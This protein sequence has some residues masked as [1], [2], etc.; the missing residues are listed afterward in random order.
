MQ[1][2]FVL[3]YVVIERTALVCGQC[4]SFSGYTAQL[5]RDLIVVMPLQVLSVDL[6]YPMKECS[7][8]SML[9]TFISHIKVVTT[10]MRLL[11]HDSLFPAQEHREARRQATARVLTRGIYQARGPLSAHG[12]RSRCPAVAP[13]AL[14]DHSA[15]RRALPPELHARVWQSLHG[16]QES[17]K[18]RGARQRDHL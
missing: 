18:P 2:W 4:V 10:H 11:V 16:C 7:S 13:V 3:R 15:H 5:R 9:S 14:Y 17:S 1:E 12:S 6:Q 8:C